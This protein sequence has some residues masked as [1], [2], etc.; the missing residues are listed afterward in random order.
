MSEDKEKSKQ[1]CFV[2]APIDKLNSDV[3][4]RS[5]QMRK[6]IFEPVAGGIC[7]YEVLRADDLP[8]P[9]LITSDYPASD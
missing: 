6:H 8:E 1:V 4:Q 7:G 5:D 2:S 9:G 3:R